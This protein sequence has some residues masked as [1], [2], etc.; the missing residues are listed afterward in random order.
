MRKF[1]GGLDSDIALYWPKNHIPRSNSESARANPVGDSVVDWCRSI[2]SG[3][4]KRP[5]PGSAVNGNIRRVTRNHNLVPLRPH[6]MLREEACLFSRT[7]LWLS[8]RCRT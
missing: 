6:T 5:W 2:V 8:G 7:N 3:T 1:D 4:W